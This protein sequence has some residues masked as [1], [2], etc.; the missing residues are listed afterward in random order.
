MNPLAMIPAAYRAALYVVAGIA[1]L[2]VIYLAAV[3]RVGVAEVALITGIVSFLGLG[4]AVSNLTRS[5]PAEEFTVYGTSIYD[6]PQPVDGN[7]DP[8]PTPLPSRGTSFLDERGVYDS[9]L[10]VAIACIVIIMV[11][12]VWLVRAF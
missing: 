4:T 5:V 2:V 10:L 12:L 3:G 7:G 8:I 9:S 1:N 11:G 6:E